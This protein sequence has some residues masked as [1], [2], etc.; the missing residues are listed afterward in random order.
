MTRRVQLISV[1]GGRWIDEPTYKIAYNVGSAIIEH[2]FGLVCGGYGG[3]MEAAAKGASEAKVRL[4]ITHL[5]IVGILKDE[6]GKAA[7]QYIEVGIP[8]GMGVARNALVVMAGSGVI[9]VGGMSG[10]LSEISMAW[11]Y[12]RP[13][14]AL[15][16]AGGWAAKVAGEPLDT[17]RSD[18][19]FAAENAEEAIKY[20]A[21]KILH[22]AG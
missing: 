17:T 9:A 18:S 13:V 10:T 1:I 4:G 22:G 15:V 14:A 3:V 21:E 6:T 5:P 11:Q 12:G 19:V 7:N 8:T 20:I 16:P 2:G